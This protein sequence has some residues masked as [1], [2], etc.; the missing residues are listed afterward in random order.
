VFAAL[1]VTAKI[2]RIGI[3]MFGKPPNFKTLVKWIRAA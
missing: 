1:W 3:L 2:F